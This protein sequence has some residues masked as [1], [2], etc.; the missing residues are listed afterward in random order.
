MS[1]PKLDEPLSHSPKSEYLI[2]TKN[3][4]ITYSAVSYTVLGIF[5]LWV[6]W[7]FFL[8][9]IFGSKTIGS[10]WAKSNFDTQYWVYL[11]PDNAE[12]K[13]YR[14]KADISRIDG[15]YWLEKVYWPNGGNSNFEDCKLDDALQ[16]NGSV[17]CST[18]EL[19][20]NG[21]DYR[22][23]TIRLGEKVWLPKT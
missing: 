21:D 18:D 23:Y 1:T 16:R 12:A 6:I 4:R 5:I 17:D 14:V 22:N 3:L 20:N 7:A 11:E 15:D 10:F 9:N 19:I 2:D 8:A 13:N